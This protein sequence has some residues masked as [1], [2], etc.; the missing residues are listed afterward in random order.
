MV[1]S[2]SGAVSQVKSRS[3]S[4]LR[5]GEARAQCLLDTLL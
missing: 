5:A 1:I 3:M 4:V 2:S